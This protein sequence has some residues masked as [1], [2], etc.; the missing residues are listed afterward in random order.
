MILFKRPQC[1]DKGAFTYYFNKN[2]M[3]GYVKALRLNFTVNQSVTGCGNHYDH[4]LAN[5]ASANF[6]TEVG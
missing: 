3:T 6:N 1:C 2:K 4:V 5:K